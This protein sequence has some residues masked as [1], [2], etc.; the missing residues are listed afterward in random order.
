MDKK[1]CKLPVII[2]EQLDQTQKQLAY[3]LNEILLFA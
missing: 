1:L 3:D 2:R